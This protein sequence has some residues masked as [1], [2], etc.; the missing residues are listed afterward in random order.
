VLSHLL[1]APGAHAPLK[2]AE[3]GAGTGIATRLLL[4]KAS[5]HGGIARYVA[6]DPSD[7]M[8][9]HLRRTL[10]GFDGSG[11]LAAL[12]AD[13]IITD[14]ADIRI[15]SGAFDTFEAGHDNDL[16]VVAQVRRQ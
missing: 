13:D 16:V 3:L 5:D 6:T 1:A 4:K 15:S 10:F 2:I 7:G 9:T 14:N 8:L 12:R 11:L